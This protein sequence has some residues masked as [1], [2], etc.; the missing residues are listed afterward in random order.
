MIPT[1]RTAASSG[2]WV[3]GRGVSVLMFGLSR[4]N[5]VVMVL[6]EA[7]LQRSCSRSA[8][9]HT[10]M[11][12]VCVFPKQ[13]LL[14]FLCIYTVF[15]WS[16]RGILDFYVT[17][18]FSLCSLNKS[19]VSN[20]IQRHESVQVCSDWWP[21]KSQTRQKYIVSIPVIRTRAVTAGDQGCDWTSW[22]HDLHLQNLFHGWETGT[23]REFFPLV[24][25]S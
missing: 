2:S 7:V 16:L 4:A 9:L 21:Q 19:S 12:R 14:V 23:E 25:S 8:L 3:G 10:H 20:R 5:N 11:W 18:T 22:L 1:W 17:S 6:K 13:V 24:K 15:L